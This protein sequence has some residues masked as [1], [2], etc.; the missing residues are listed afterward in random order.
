[1]TLTSL[2]IRSLK[3]STY[4]TKQG[5]VRVGLE[6]RGG[7]SRTNPPAQPP[8][9]RETGGVCEYRAGAARG[10]LER[11]CPPTP[12][13]GRCGKP[14][15]SP[16]S[17]RPAGPGRV[18]SAATSCRGTAQGG[19]STA[20]PH[21]RPPSRAGPG[22]GG[23]AGGSSGRAGRARRAGWNGREAPRGGPKPAPPRAGAG[24][25]R[26]GPEERRRRPGRT[27][28]GRG[29]QRGGRTLS[30]TSG[31]TL[32]SEAMAAPVSG[33]LRFP[34]PTPEMT[35][36]RAPANAARARRPRDPPRAHAPPGP[37][38]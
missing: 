16:R 2:V 1:M 10:P 17:G 33:P 6:Q 9:S 37:G 34:G 21:P 4:R 5:Q 35:S 29:E 30:F 24:R 14:H 13:S 7:R 15:G 19:P 23:D 22:G 27:G 12:H 20:Q 18:G 36:R 28:R 26:H 25:A 31:S 3:E 8:P 38:R 11:L 32:S